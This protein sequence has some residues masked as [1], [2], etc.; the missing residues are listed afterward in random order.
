MDSF[1]GYRVDGHWCVAIGVGLAGRDWACGQWVLPV[2]DGVSAGRDYPIIH[3]AIEA[4]ISG[5]R[6]GFMS[7]GD[8]VGCCPQTIDCPLFLGFMYHVISI[9]S[10]RIKFRSPKPQAGGRPCQISGQHEAGS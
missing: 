9:G 1:G 10:V 6:E 4:E 8:R 3:D 5:G 7:T 2:I